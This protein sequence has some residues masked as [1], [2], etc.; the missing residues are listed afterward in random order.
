MGQQIPVSLDS[1]TFHEITF[2]VG[3]EGREDINSRYGCSDYI[4]ARHQS[5]IFKKKA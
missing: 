2:S 1:T 3:T 4:S 5:F